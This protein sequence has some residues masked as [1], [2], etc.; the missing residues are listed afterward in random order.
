MRKFV[1]ILFLLILPLQWT[2][3]AVAA[4]C[5]HEQDGK[6]QQHLGHH[7]HEHQASAAQVD[8]APGNSDF[9]A[10]CPSCHAHFAQA[11]VDADQ[12]MLPVSQSRGAMAYLAFIPSPPTA[13][14]FRPP[15]ADLA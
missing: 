7:A 3:A 14:L 15:L 2:T 6:T 5:Q 9:D 12:P 13:S 8:Y 11:I 4:Y 10:D 1:A